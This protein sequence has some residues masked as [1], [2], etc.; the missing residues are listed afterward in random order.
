MNKICSRLLI[1]LMI[2]SVEALLPNKTLASTPDLLI[3]FVRHGERSPRM[4]L[5]EKLWPMGQGEMTTTGLQNSYL[6]GQHLR[7][8]Y[9]NHNPPGVWHNGFSRHQAKGINRTIQSAMAILQGF[10]PAGLEETGLPQKI[11]IPPVYA[12][13]QDSDILFSPHYVCPGFVK[14]IEVLEN[15]P[16]WVQK[17]ASYGE[18]LHYW[19]KLIQRPAK[20]YSLTPLMDSVL[21]RHQNHIPLPDSLTSN[22]E[23]QL[24]ELLDWFFDSMVKDQELVQLFT[25]NF[26][27]ELIKTLKKHQSCKDLQCERFVLYVASDNNLLTFLAAMGAPRSS[28]VNYSSHLDMV[29]SMNGGEKQVS[30]YLNDQP[31]S[32]PGCPRSCRLDHWIEALERVLPEDWAA[33]CAM[34]AGARLE[35]SDLMGSN[36]KAEEQK[37]NDEVRELYLTNPVQ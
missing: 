25:A 27:R 18:R 6:L 16:D 4:P 23:Q 12:P 10:Y 29:V 17:K 9:F 35:S 2:I 20:I 11:Q 5:D 22:D 37:N 33:L 36:R 3:S 21:I 28:N 26:I 31:L 15:S 13:P 34:G 19:A 8:R 7:K 32:L 24:I 14:R 30:L 1:P